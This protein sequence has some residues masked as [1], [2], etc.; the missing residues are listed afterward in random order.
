M[1]P[2]LMTKPLAN[3]SKTRS[4]DSPAAVTNERQR[5]WPRHRRHAFVLAWLLWA[6]PMLVIA[7]LVAHAPSKHTVTLGSYHLAAENWWAG[8]NL[9]VGPAGMN[10]LPHFAVL[11]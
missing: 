7:A 10:Y 4:I 8:R 9:Y 3:L 1:P 6:V 5:L 2:K 11:Y